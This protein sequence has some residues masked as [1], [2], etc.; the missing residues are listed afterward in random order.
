MSRN[1]F[2]C[3]YRSRGNPYLRMSYGLQ[4]GGTRVAATVF[5]LVRA[6]SRNPTENSISIPESQLLYPAKKSLISLTVTGFHGRGRNGVRGVQ[7]ASLHIHWYCGLCFA[8]RYASI[9]GITREGRLRL[10]IKVGRLPQLFF[11]EVVISHRLVST[12]LFSLIRLLLEHYGGWD[13]GVAAQGSCGA[14]G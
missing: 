6:L 11:P 9:E 3:S 5:S 4:P 7:H 2:N 12:I 14:N 8:S 10:C 1:R 13:L